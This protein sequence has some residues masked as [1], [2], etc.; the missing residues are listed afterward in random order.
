MRT[1]QEERRAL[2]VGLYAAYHILPE[3][4]TDILPRLLVDTETLLAVA[5]SALDYFLSLPVIS[6]PTEAWLGPLIAAVADAAGET[7]P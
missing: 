1:T 4:Q 3:E 7:Q 2:R 6:R 5:S